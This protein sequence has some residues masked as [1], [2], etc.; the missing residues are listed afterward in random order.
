[1]LGGLARRAAFV[2]KVRSER[3]PALVLDSGDLFFDAGSTRDPERALAKARLLGRT[4]NRMRAA[5]IN[6]GDLDL[7]QGLDFLR[8]EASRGVPLI[9]A[10]LLDPSSRT[11]IFPPYVIHQISG[12]RVAFFGLLSPEFRAEVGPA[13]QK[14]VGD[15]IWI[16]EPVEAARETVE[17]LRNQADLIVLLSDLGL[18]KDSALAKAIPGIH[19]I[20]G[21]HDGRFHT[22]PYHEG[23]TYILHA[24][25]KGMHMGRLQ[26]TL[27]NSA[28]PFQ[29]KGKVN[30]VQE[31]IRNLDNHLRA[32]EKERE[33]QPSQEI[34]RRIQFVNRQKARFQEDLGKSSIAFSNGNV[35]LWAL[36]T[37]EATLPEDEELQRWIKEAGIEKD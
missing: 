7:I 10:N 35:F 17:K 32:L 24:S 15:R 11:P 14:A 4:Y 36:V 13:I 6:V 2:E 28:S 21:G 19:F 27:R 29:D 33:R 18:N 25:A 37:L 16:K 5:A 23:K 31:Q 34:E 12:K 1:M 3:Q 22:Q 20:L 9:S 8:D 26:L 30:Q